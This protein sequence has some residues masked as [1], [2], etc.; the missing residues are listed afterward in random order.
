LRGREGGEVAFLEQRTLRRRQRDALA[1]SGGRRG[2][3]KKGG[4]GREKKKWNRKRGK[5][6]YWVVEKG[7]QDI[8]CGCSERTKLVKP[9]RDAWCES[10]EASRGLLQKPQKGDKKR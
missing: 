5:V 10:F 2:E 8:P 1:A 9:E 4:R 6:R 7:D 3:E